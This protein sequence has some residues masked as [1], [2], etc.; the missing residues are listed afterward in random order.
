VKRCPVCFGLVNKKAT[1]CKHCSSPIGEDN[2]YYEYINNGFSL[3]NRE[4]D[5]FN[6]KVESIKGRIF[7]R[8]QYS[9]EELLHS[10][11]IDKIKAIAGKMRSDIENWKNRGAVSNDLV[12]YYTEKASLLDDKFRFMIRRLKARQNNIWERLSEFLICSYYFIINIAL[13]QIKNMIIPSVSNSKNIMRP[14]TVLQ[15]TAENFEHFLD[16]IRDDTKNEIAD[17]FISSKRGR[18]KGPA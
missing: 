11:H 15:K 7:P 18:M 17:E 13:Y 5:A 12:N 3:I 9:E 10:S 1:K 2:T 14:F 16:V 6:Q 8:H 4:C